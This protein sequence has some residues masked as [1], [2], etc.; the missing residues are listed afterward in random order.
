MTGAFIIETK[1]E[2]YED[3]A[4]TTAFILTQIVQ[5]P[6]SSISIPQTTFGAFVGP[7]PTSRAVNCLFYTSLG[8]SLAN[9]TVGLLCL[10]WL[11]G[12]GARC[13]GI[14]PQTYLLFRHRRDQAFQRW[15]AKG[16]ILT[17]PLLLLAS[18]ISFFVAIL[19]YT[20]SIDWAIAS[21]LYIIFGIAFL[22]L[23]FTTFT[24]A[25][26]NIWYSLFT[27]QW[28]EDV[29]FPPFH[30]LQS[31]IVLR[32]LLGC[33]PLFRR[34][35]KIRPSAALPAL[36]CALDWVRVDQ[37]WTDWTG[38]WGQRCTSTIFPLVLSFG[39]RHDQDAVYHCF[40]DLFP[41]QGDL[42]GTRRLHVYRRM[43]QHVPDSGPTLLQANNQLI[44]HLASL[45]NGGKRFQ[46]L[47]KLDV[48]LRMESFHLSSGSYIPISPFTTSL[49][50]RTFR[51]FAT[52]HERTAPLPTSSFSF[53]T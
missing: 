45:L 12:L 48:E 32:A 53:D 2:L 43:V 11:R 9:V 4:R 26:V 36:Q 14:T 34:L 35:T 41:A 18:L 44:R 6:N 3:P 49:T 28:P 46:D 27:Q 7:S 19:L 39:T 33:V 1:K 24:P 51:H 10:Q 29:A 21:P 20:S 8:F 38:S 42:P 13:D 31:W 16:T 40:N 5:Q 50:A 52:A 23:L 22:F 37:F 15:G 30:S 25:F 17:L 47:G